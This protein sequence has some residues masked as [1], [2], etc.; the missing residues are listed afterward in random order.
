ML[1]C[2][3]FASLTANAQKEMVVSIPDYEAYVVVNSDGVNVRKAASATSPKL[4]AWNSDGGSYETVVK[5]Y[6]EGENPTKYRAN[7]RTGAWVEA[8]HPSAGDALPVIG[9]SGDWYRVVMTLNGSDGSNPQT[10]AVYI[11]KRF[12]S[13]H[14]AMSISE[15]FAYGF[16]TEGESASTLPLNYRTKGAY[17][18]I[19]FAVTTLSDSYGEDYFSAQIIVPVMAGDRFVCMQKVDMN[20]KTASAYKLS[21]TTQQEENVMTGEMESWTQAF[22]YMPSVS[23]SGRQNG[24]VN[25]LKNLSD[26]DFLQLVNFACKEP[27]MTYGK[28]D[29]G[30]VFYTDRTPTT[31]V[32]SSTYK[33]K[34]GKRPGNGFTLTVVK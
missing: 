26:N 15:P 3:L 19:P 1:F 2:A 32:D 28:L 31:Y 25:A 23:E 20:V 11:M 7:S 14:T 8:V 27:G 4:M 21:L 5:Y 22:L 29:D 12:A 24:V 6:F 9:E 30:T 34:A 10:K 16:A 33:A 18:K 17:T 13:K